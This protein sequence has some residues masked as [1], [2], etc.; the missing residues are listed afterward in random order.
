M[1]K[2]LERI[3]KNPYYKPNAKQR[4]E[5]EEDEPVIS[6]GEIPK[7]NFDIE[8]HPFAPKRKSVNRQK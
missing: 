8:K 4:K 2:T 3:R 5:L 7:N 1:N 6:F